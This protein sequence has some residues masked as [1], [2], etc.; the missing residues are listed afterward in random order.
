MNFKLLSLFS[1]VA[2]LFLGAA[3]AFAQTRTVKG[4]IL[5]EDGLPA[6]GAYVSVEGVANKGTVTDLDG[7]FTLEGV[8]TSAK[9][10]VI[11]HMGFLEQ[12][13]AIADNVTVTLKQ[14]AEVLESAVVTGMTKVDRRLFT[15]ST[16]KVNA[17]DAKIS[18]I[19]DISRSLEGRVAGVSVQNVSGTFGTAPKIRVRG[20]TSIY[21]SSKPLWVV[22][23]V[24]IEDVVE[25]DAEDLSSGDANTLISSAIAGLNSDDI[26]SFD[27]LKDGS[28][29]S[30]YGARA[31]AGVIVVTTKKGRSGHSSITYN[32]EYTIRMKPSYNNFNIMNSQD[33]MSVYQ[34]LEQKGYLLYAGTVN[35]SE[36]GIYGKMYSLISLFDETSGMF[37]LPNTPEAKAAYLRSAE[38]RNT[39][40]FDRLFTYSVQH[41]HSVSL[42]GG[43]DKSNY[44]ASLSILDD[45]GWSIQSSVRRYTANL[46]TT[47]K[48]FPNLSLNLISN[49]SYR[50]QRAPGTLGSTIDAVNG[51]VQRD[52]D[53]NPYSYAL[54]TSRALD[55]DEF[56]T[57]NYAPFNIFHELNNNYLDIDVTNIRIQGELKWDV[58]SHLSLSALAAYKYSGTSRE[59]YILDN[60][61]QAMAYRAMQ[62]TTIRDANTFLYTDPDIMFAVPESILPVGGIFQRNDNKMNGWD[63]RLSANYSKSFGGIHSITAYAGMEVNSIDRHATWFRGWGMQYDMGEMANYYYKVFKKGSEDNSQYYTLGNSHERRAAFFG[64]FTYGLKNRYSINGT[65][66]YEGSNRLG[67]SSSARWLPTWNVSGRWNIIDEPWMVRLKPVLSHA[68]VKL[69]YSLTAESG[70]SW[71]TNSNVV[72][73]A[74][75]PWRNNVN[76]RET[77]LTIS[78]L[79]NPDLT[80]EKKHEF[81]VGLEAGFLDNRINFAGDWYKRNNYDLI[82]R[83]NTQGIGGEV[84]KYGNVASM[85]SDGFEL[86]LTTQNIKTKDFKWTTNFVY[87]HSH[88]KVTKLYTNLRVIDL[89]RGSGFAMEGYPN[90]SIFSIPFRGLN[91]EGIPTFVDQDSEYNPATGE[92]KEHIS[93]TGIYFQTS[94]PDKMHFLEYSGVADPTDI[95]SI[96]NT[97]EWKG[98]RLNIFVTGSFGNVV[99]LD[100]VFRARYSDLNSMPRE[101]KNRWVIP[102]DEAKTNIPVI[103][104]R[105]QNTNDGHLSYAYNAYNYSTERI[106]KGDFVR[107]KEV[108]LSYDLPKKWVSAISF[109]SASVKLQATNLF[110]LYA[111]K[112]LNGQ[113]PEFFNTGGVAVPVPRQFTLTVKL[114]L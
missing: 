24:I 62:T 46:N 31:M 67:K 21:G 70:P 82:G 101:F 92:L 77:I 8:P 107:L 56:Y 27:I 15:G 96:G 71:V 2:A 50:T 29:T 113:D 85:K 30:I 75:N 18:G 87:S 63:T 48:I 108:S 22:D 105:I 69:S 33:Q 43:T 103:A 4:T 106:A 45:P 23:G 41:N 90:H 53:I 9:T 97:F 109:K 36:S 114:G 11:T 3:S 111:D 40:W 37:G 89:I 94:D 32:G 64:T 39:D 93:T 34:E 44:Y 25:V 88:N 58:N 98:F 12:K 55:P 51:A 80:F 112:K 28:A 54:N 6:I 72:I 59:H 68:A 66:R 65:I 83:T 42:S 49:T 84:M 76:D 78:S 38:F 16:A 86:S 10:L 13:V 102:G 19:A 61:N 20:A 104:S 99:R 1:C 7:H 91:E 52:F 60:S 35:A 26:E 74:Y 79:A 5:E 95:G 47:Y 57:R 73:E 110:L 17:E 100:P 81:N 14:D